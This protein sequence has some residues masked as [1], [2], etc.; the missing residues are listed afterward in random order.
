MIVGYILVNVGLVLG[1]NG[2]WLLDRV[3]QKEVSV[4]NFFAGG[5]LLLCS[6]YIA[7]ATEGFTVAGI[8]LMFA[9]TFLWVAFNQYNEADGRGLGWFCGAVGV[10]LVPICLTNLQAAVTT[11]DYWFTLI[12]GLWALLFFLYFALLVLKTNTAKLT[13]MVAVFNSLV[14]GWLPAYF[15]LQGIVGPGAQG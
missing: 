6:L 3:G 7:F 1:I 12:W 2:L 13:G 9:F 15:V 14:T 11:W 8:V 10:Y 5:M 4:A